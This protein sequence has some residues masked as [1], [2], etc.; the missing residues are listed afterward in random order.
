MDESTTQPESIDDQTTDDEPRRHSRQRTVTA[1]VKKLVLIEGQHSPMEI[2]KI[3]I[4]ALKK[5]EIKAPKN[6]FII[7]CLP[8]ETVMQGIVPFKADDGLISNN[9]L[10]LNGDMQTLT[11]YMTRPY[12]GQ[13]TEISLSGNIPFRSTLEHELLVLRSRKNHKGQ[14]WR[15][16]WGTTPKKLKNPT[17]VWIPASEVR[18]SDFLLCP[19]KFPVT[20]ALP[21]FYISDHHLAKPINVGILP[22]IDLAWLFGLYIADGGKTGTNSLSFTLN[23]KTDVQRVHRALAYFEVTADIDEYDKYFVVRV[24]SVSLAKTFRGWFGEDC[25]TKHIP[26]FLYGWGENCLK[27]LIDGYTEGDGHASHVS[28]EKLNGQWVTTSVKQGAPLNGSYWATTVSYQ[29]A[30]QLW[31]LL[32]ALKCYPIIDNYHDGE[33]TNFGERAKSWIV[34]WHGPNKK[35]RHDTFY[36]GGYYCMPV[37]SVV[38]IDFDGNVHNFSVAN[39]ETYVANGVVCHNCIIKDRL[40]KD[41]FKKMDPVLRNYREVIKKFGREYK[42]SANQIA[43]L[44][45]SLG[46]PVQTQEVCRDGRSR[47]ARQKMRKTSVEVK[48]VGK[49]P[50]PKKELSSGKKK[51]TL[52]DKC[53]E[54]FHERKVHK[55]SPK[56]V[57]ARCQG[58]STHDI[59]PWIEKGGSGPC[60]C[61]RFKEKSK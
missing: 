11:D 32:V 31:Y 19:T 18:D 6:L 35:T 9:V 57:R 25:Y 20:A 12:K 45:T 4:S 30:Y 7:Y 52:Q 36:Y 46:I 40:M 16:H 26:E 13:L 10:D 55:L 8:G 54:C 27:N 39:T 37:K 22:D 56:G 23:N 41:Y 3:V 21:E 38:Q 28:Y 1:L 49:L 24:N 61:R 60:M 33:V 2:A 43:K 50:A 34:Y 47:E 29:L 51:K 44:D 58:T 5:K 17:P 53:G 14:T 15:P 48:R 42:F 59:H